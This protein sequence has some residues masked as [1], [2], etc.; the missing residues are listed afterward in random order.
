[1][2]HQLMVASKRNH[3]AASYS[4]GRNQRVSMRASSIAVSHSLI[5]SFVLEH[6][7]ECVVVHAE[8]NGMS[9]QR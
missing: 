2:K 4:N 7:D 8:I 5:V 3:L 9:L 6:T 1:V